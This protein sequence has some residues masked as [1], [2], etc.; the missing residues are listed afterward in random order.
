[1]FTIRYH[2]PGSVVW[3]RPFNCFCVFKRPAPNPYLVFA[4]DLPLCLPIAERARFQYDLEYF[5]H[6][7]WVLTYHFFMDHSNHDSPK[8]LLRI[9]LRVLEKGKD[10]EN[11]FSHSLGTQHSCCSSLL[12]YG[13]FALHLAKISSCSQFCILGLAPRSPQDFVWCCTNLASYM[14]AC[15]ELYVQFITHLYFSHWLHWILRSTHEGSILR[16]LLKNLSL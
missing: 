14:H 7:S 3:T 6:S 15:F 13:V 5:Q 2:L 1:M 12:W 10:Y 9:N 4:Y 8:L 16:V 11:Q